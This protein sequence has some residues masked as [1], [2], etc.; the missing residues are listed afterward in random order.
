[1]EKKATELPAFII[2]RIP[3]RFTYDNNYFSD[4]YQ[5]IPFG[6]Y[7]T[8]IKSLIDDVDVKLGV[9]FLIIRK[10]IVSWRKGSCSRVL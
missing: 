3:V 7:N 4:K 6:G 9:D 8:L 2:K 5:E 10:N 1:M